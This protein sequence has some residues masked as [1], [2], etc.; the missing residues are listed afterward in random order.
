MILRHI[1]RKSELVAGVGEKNT[2]HDDVWEHALC[3]PAWIQNTHQGLQPQQRMNQLLV[4]C[5]LN[6]Y[7]LRFV[8]RQP[9]KWDNAHYGWLVLWPGGTNV[10]T[11]LRALELIVNIVCNNAAKPSS[12]TKSSA[13]GL[14]QKELHFC[15][16]ATYFVCNVSNHI[17]SSKWGEGAVTCS[18]VW[19]L[20]MANV[21]VCFTRIQ[22]MLWYS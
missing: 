21:K 16:E 5:K 9:P 18:E 11:D 22:E 1:Q 2:C 17:R 4:I 13:S 20:G 6:V 15:L 8:D 12:S 10:Q 14:W 19:V 7:C 3:L